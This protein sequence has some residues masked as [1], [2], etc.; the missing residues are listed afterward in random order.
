MFVFILNYYRYHSERLHSLIKWWVF[1]IDL[2]LALLPLN[3][4]FPK[5]VYK[6]ND[7]IK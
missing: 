7:R 5:A 4:N 6:I 2:D 1:F 3:N